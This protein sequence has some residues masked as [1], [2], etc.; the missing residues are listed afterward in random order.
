[1][2]AES[3]ALV[4]SAECLNCRTRR[5]NATRGLCQQCY[6]DPEVL[7][8]FPRRVNYTVRQGRDWKTEIRQSRGRSRWVMSPTSSAGR[9]CR[10]VR[11]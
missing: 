11:V 5:A 8:R 7:A 2:G 9:T 3:E 1:M 6:R 4:R 10:A